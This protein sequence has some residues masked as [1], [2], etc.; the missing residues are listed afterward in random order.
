[1]CVM[2][3]AYGCAV[4]HEQASKAKEGLLSCC[5]AG[6]HLRRSCV[7]YSSTRLLRFMLPVLP[8]QRLPTLQNRPAPGL[9][10]LLLLLLP[11]LW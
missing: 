4:A 11:L 5:R 9:P 6:A 10:E 1:M 3:A 8:Q 2:Y 7:Q